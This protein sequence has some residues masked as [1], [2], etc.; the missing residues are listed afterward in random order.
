MQGT[1]SFT[2]GGVNWK[3]GKYFLFPHEYICRLWTTKTINVTSGSNKFISRTIPT[4]IYNMN[5]IENA[6]SS[7]MH[8]WVEMAPLLRKVPSKFVLSM[9]INQM[10]I[11]AILMYRWRLIY[12]YVKYTKF[13]LPL[14]VKLK[15]SCTYGR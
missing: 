15:T 4:N 11:A 12:P 3:A 1:V 14:P 5:A 10:L 7:I 2:R 13:T 9:S 6:N 8:L